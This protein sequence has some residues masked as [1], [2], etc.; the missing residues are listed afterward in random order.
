M[1]SGL[2][3]CYV[4]RVVGNDRG[5]GLGGKRLGLESQ[6]RTYLK[7]GQKWPDGQLVD[8]A[9]PE[10]YLARALSRRFRDALN[11]RELSNVQASEK[12]GMSTHTIHD[13]L[14]G[15]SWA[16]FS[17]IARIEVRLSA[18]LWNTAHRLRAGMP[19]R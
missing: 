15:K 9:P 4:L 10:A 19:K 16:R 3:D 1:V 6:P 18:E 7:P 8:D 14:N 11:T 5:L 12:L 13:L 2:P 17:V